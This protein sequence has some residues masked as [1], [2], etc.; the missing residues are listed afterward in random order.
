MKMIAATRAVKNGQKRD[1]VIRKAIK[2]L[3][4]KLVVRLAILVRKVVVSAFSIFALFLKPGCTKDQERFSNFCHD[5]I[6]A[7]FASNH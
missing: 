3:C 1:I 5:M 7:W 4:G 2:I 6:Y